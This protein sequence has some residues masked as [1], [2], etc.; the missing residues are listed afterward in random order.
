MFKE[1]I[2]KLVTPILSSNSLL[3]KERK[4][5]NDFFRHPFLKEK[6]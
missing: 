6:K 2:N 4:N 5:Q 1:I 3:L